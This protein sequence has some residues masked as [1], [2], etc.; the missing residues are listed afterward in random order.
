MQS[1]DTDLQMQ[2]MSLLADQIDPKIADLGSGSGNNALFLLPALPEG[3]ELTLIEQ[4]EYLLVE[5]QRRLAELQ[6]TLPGSSS[7]PSIRYLRH[8]L[9]GWLSQAPAVDLLCNSALFDLF[10]AQE[11]DHFISVIALRQIPVYSTLNYSGVTFEPEDKLDQRYLQLFEQHMCRQL[12]RGL[13]LGPLLHAALQQAAGTSTSLELKYAK[14]PWEIR[15]VDN[16]FMQMNLAFYQR[17]ISAM[18][19]SQQE[20]SD[21][22]DWLQ[23]KYTQLEQGKLTLTVHHYDYLIT[24]LEPKRA[25]K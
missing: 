9:H 22:D 8:D 19:S 7:A 2:A 15:S 11:L 1:R 25:G 12:D 10:T 16:H 14:S 3:C 4:H 24:P 5:S 17:G 6:V 20:L 13:P 23:Q 18:L 21:F